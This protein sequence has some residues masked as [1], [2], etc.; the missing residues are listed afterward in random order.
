MNKMISFVISVFNEEESLPELIGQ[1][2]NVLKEKLKGYNCEII[3]VND[4]S[5]DHSLDIMKKLEKENPE[6]SVISFRKNLGKA[7]ALNEGFK[8]AKGG[9]V[10]TMDA[11]LQDDASNIPN[12]LEKLDGKYDLV[13]GW[14]KH[15]FDSLGKVIPS[16]IFNFFVGK[17]SGVP[18]HDLNSGLRIMKSEVAKELYLYGEMHRFIPVL[19]VQRGFKV[20]EIPVEH[21][22]RKYG[23]SKYGPERLIRGFLDF[24]TVLFLNTYG[25][26]PLHFFGLLGT[27]SIIVGVIFATYLSTLHF[28]GQTI[29]NRPLLTLSMLLIIAGLQLLS[30]G[31]IAEMIVRKESKIDE[32]LP[33]DYESR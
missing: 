1:I 20:A 19:A 13:V 32:K 21:N 12:L 26:K 6:I 27:A 22:P 31:F 9:L 33:T 30:I 10:V 14:K 2:K 8:V 15:R 17:I 29:G 28:T 5:E 7:A 24:L 18:L 25:Q 3:L 4:G 16:R 11:D 23:S